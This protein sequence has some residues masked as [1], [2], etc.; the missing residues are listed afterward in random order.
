V[1]VDG[2]PY[3]VDHAYQAIGRAGTVLTSGL[4][5]FNA[6]ALAAGLI[7][8]D[9]IADAGTEIDHLR[10]EASLDGGILN[11][12]ANHTFLF[13]ATDWQ[14]NFDTAGTAGVIRRAPGTGTRSLAGNNVVLNEI[15]PKPN[16]EWVE[17]ANPTAS[18]INLNGWM[19]QRKTG[20]NWN[21]IYT[22][23]QTIG[24]WG[25]GSEYLTVDFAPNTL[26][27][28]QTSIRLVAA[29]GTEVDRTTY[30][31]AGS[32]NTWAR[33]KHAQTGK[34]VDT[35][36]DGSDFY[37][38]LLPTK[39]APNDRH[40]P[41]ITVAKIAN[42]V[43]AAPGDLIAYTVYYNNTDTGRANTVWVNDTLPNDV[44]FV[45]SSV[46]YQSTDGKTYRWVFT[47]VGPLTPNSFTIT[48]RVNATAG[49]N[50]VLR[51]T[52]GLNYTDQLGRKQSASLAMAN[53]S[54]SRPVIV[55]EKI[56]DKPT[57]LPGDILTYTVF[58]NNTGGARANHVWI[59][60]T[61]PV[62]VTYQSANPAP[63]QI[64]G[65]TLRWHFTN[66]AA[67]SHSLTITVLVDAFP[68]AVLVNWAFLNYT[69]QNDYKLAGSQDSAV[70]AIPEFETLLLPIAIPFVLYGIR[71]RKKEG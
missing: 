46:A 42:R 39:T 53:T 58:Y 19:L 41:R 60:D 36:T 16:P 51:N 7:P 13:F 40:R 5:A 50:Q 4:F 45:S 3:G 62:G 32:G 18:A 11:L 63:N 52:V 23:T 8:W 28:G 35:D 33:F 49:N 31:G 25:S 2:I 69:A 44:A 61:L 37:I 56:V 10:L 67:G 65:Q 59:N 66:V 9:R 20:N 21:T 70:T 14:S 29:N 1:I 12:T 22:Y 55:V 43:S 30:S 48:V 6:S 47:N 64:I 24:A 15:S 54:V 26:P 68:P 38:S 27:N 34:P 17:L 71:R 57:A